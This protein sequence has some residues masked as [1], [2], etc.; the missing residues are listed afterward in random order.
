[1]S[2]SV[3]GQFRIDRNELPAYVITND[4]DTIGIV[5]SIED[6]QKIDK[7]LQLLESVEK[8]NINLDSTKF[9]Y[10]SLVDNMDQKIFLQKTKIINLTTQILDRD[11]IINNLKLTIAKNDTIILNNGI[12][13]DNMDTMIEQRD[14]EIKKQKRLKGLAILS[15]A[16]VVLLLIVFN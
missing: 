6:V 1:M 10:V 5:F 11:N 15:G 14:K 3:F 12:V 2:F 13:M 4:N 8:L 9:Y 7:S 16:V